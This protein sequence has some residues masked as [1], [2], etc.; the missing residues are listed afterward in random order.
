ML[1]DRRL[2][3]VEAYR[4]VNRKGVPYFLCRVETAK[5]GFRYVF[6]RAIQGQPVRHLPPDHEVAESVNGVVSLR[7]VR[8]QLISDAEIELVKRAVPQRGLGFPVERQGQ[9][10]V[11]Y[12]W[13]GG[14]FTPAVRF[15]LRDAAARDFTVDR[16][17]YRGGGPHWHELGY[18]PLDKI[19]KPVLRALGTEA[20]FDLI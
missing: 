12:E 14:S 10:M 11:V 13:L 4:Y 6:S 16:M 5:G 2:T 19:A 8:P 9:T 3:G 1:C 18:G 20:F 7:R 17:A 15:T